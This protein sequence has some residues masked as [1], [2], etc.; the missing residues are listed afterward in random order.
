MK[1]SRFRD[2]ML[3]YFFTV[4]VLP[5]LT[6]GLLGPLL[7]TREVSDLLAIHT[8]DLVGQVTANLELTI[9]DHQKI[10]EMIL[11]DPRTANLY[12]PDLGD[13]E[14][15]EI[16]ELFNAAT[17]SHPEITGLIAV[18]SEDRMLSNEFERILRD[19]LVDEDWFTSAQA[20]DSSFSLI[21]RPLGRNLL[22][23]TGVDPDEIVS[24]IKSVSPVVPGG[25]SGVLMADL[26]LSYLE[27]A[28]RESLKGESGETVGFFC[29]VDSEGSFVYAPVNTIVYRINPDWFVN[30][31]EVIERTIQGRGY[32]LV[33]SES[34]Y[35]GWKTVGVYYLE[36]ALKPIRFVQYSALI[37]ALITI[38]LSV[39]ISFIYTNTISKPVLYLLSVMERAGHGDLQVRYHGHSKDEIDQLG[40][41]LNSMLE[42]IEDLLSLV[43]KEQ[44]NKRDAELRIMQQQIKPHFLYNTLDTILWMAEE[45]EPQQIVEV[46]TALTKLF[47]IALSQGQEV[48]SLKDEMEH[49]RSYL[50]IQKSR[51]EDKFHFELHCQEELYPLRVQKMI[52]Q[53]LVEN[54]I[55]HGIKEKEGRGTVEV[56]VSLQDD[57]LFLTISDD[58]VGI[59]GGVL[60]TI[61]EGLRHMDHESDRTAFALYN[62]NDRIRLT[63]GDAYG[64][65]IVSEK[66]TRTIVTITHPVIWE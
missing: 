22:N 44:Q 17:V 10:L 24:L 18:S 50:I 62:V 60:A 30:S 32:Q 55:Y 47:R 46:V 11:S 27:E 65:A 36:D 26:S 53:P 35:T 40:D 6:L 7:Y 3:I 1:R 16:L 64:I 52:L 56:H 13:D 37:I 14:A 38:A 2:R 9:R 15:A 12:N 34:A 31:S 42:R 51:Y 66:N 63:Y 5:V 39:L 23:R 25:P 49:V 20:S 21:T 8:R 48:I 45:N 54:S 58:G 4:M 61:N 33:Y 29:I 28:F 57:G 41:G 59:D 19:P 43:Y